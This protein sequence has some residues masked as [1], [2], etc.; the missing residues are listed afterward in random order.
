MISYRKYLRLVWFV[1]FLMLFGLS[2]SLIMVYVSTFVSPDIMDSCGWALS[3]L[4]VGI[5]FFSTFPWL[6]IHLRVNQLRNQLSEDSDFNNN[7]TEGASIENYSRHKIIMIVMLTIA[8]T[9]IILNFIL[10]WIAYLKSKDVELFIH[11]VV[12]VASVLGF[13]SFLLMYSIDER[14]KEIEKSISQ[15]KN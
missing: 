3:A 1:R 14:F 5:I 7:S 11:M 4:T 13:N 8:I 2:T 10:G 15:Y 12:V 6:R 9:L